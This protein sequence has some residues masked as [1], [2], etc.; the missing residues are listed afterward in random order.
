[1][2]YKN[3]FTLIELLVVVLII[4]ILAAIALPRYMSAV[5]RTRAAE[6][7][8]LAKDFYLAQKRYSLAT[9]VYAD[10]FADLDITLDRGLAPTSGAVCDNGISSTD[11]I[12]RQD[13]YEVILNNFSPGYRMVSVLRLAG[14]NKC[15]GFFYFLEL[16]IS[17]TLP[18]NRLLCAERTGSPSEQNEYCKSVGFP[19][20]VVTELGFSYF[21]QE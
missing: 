13:Y 2:K 7:E 15:G 20:L 16:P 5:E 10:R 3:G 18:I 12:R 6:M 19:I 14:D 8:T 17:Y 4:G 21:S 9:G 11:A 1:M